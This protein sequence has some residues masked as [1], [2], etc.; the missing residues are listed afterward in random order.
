MKPTTTQL[1]I[2]RYALYTPIP[3][4]LRSRRTP[5]RRAWDRRGASCRRA[6]S[7]RRAVDR[8]RD[9]ARGAGLQGRVAVVK[10]VRDE[11]ERTE[12]R[13]DRG[14]GRR[15]IGERSPIGA[16][17][18]SPRTPLATARERCDDNGGGD[19]EQDDGEGEA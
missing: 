13:D 19:V 6:L 4:K 15:R 9:G 18:V 2:A 10:R 3:S 7:P 12:D 14:P 17:S 1:R 8:H 16:P 5:A 11:A